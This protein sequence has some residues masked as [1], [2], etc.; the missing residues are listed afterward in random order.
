MHSP[1]VERWWWLRW[2]VPPHFGHGFLP[3]TTFFAARAFLGFFGA[4]VFLAV[5]AG[6][7]ASLAWR[8]TAATSWVAIRDTGESHGAHN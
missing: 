8:S 5:G 2:S 4:A 7:A 6:L 1:E 3:A